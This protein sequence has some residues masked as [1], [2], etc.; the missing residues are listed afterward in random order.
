MDDYLPN[1]HVRN[2]PVGKLFKCYNSLFKYLIL[3]I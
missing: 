1:G 3:D 2:V